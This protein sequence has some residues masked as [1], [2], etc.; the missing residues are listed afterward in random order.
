MRRVPSLVL[1][2]AAL[3]ALAACATATPA[4]TPDPTAG[5]FVVGGDRPATVEIPAGLDPETPTPLLVLLHGYGSTAED[6]ERAFSLESAAVDRGWLAV[7]PE[8]TTDRDGRQFWNAGTI[9]C[10]NL[11][12]SDV[13]DSAYLSGLIAEIGERV[14]VDPKRVF[15]FGHSN[16]A[17]MAYRMACDHADQV[18]AIVSLAGVIVPEEIC[19]P[20]EPVNVLQVHGTADTA[21][22]FDGSGG[23]PSA[24]DDVETWAAHDGCDPVPHESGPDLD[25]VADLDGDESHQLTFEGCDPGGSVTLWT[26]EGGTHQPLPSEG[27]RDLVLDWFEAHA[28]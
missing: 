1:A 20:T 28:R 15:I 14:S 4:S 19:H 12:A 21:V 22:P 3:L 26:M 2:A 13:D 17:F 6:L 27:A 7:S 25:L 10:C 23:A 5:P 18:A 16:G 8:G 11:Y 24:M 9:G